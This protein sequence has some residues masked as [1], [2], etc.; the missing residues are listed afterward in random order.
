MIEA[1]DGAVAA[2]S[3]LRFEGEKFLQGLDKTM[4]SFREAIRA[5]VNRSITDNAQTRR[6]VR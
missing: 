4:K 2:L 6:I 1:E 5:E 3:D